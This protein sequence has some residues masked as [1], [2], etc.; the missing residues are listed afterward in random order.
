MQKGVG[1]ALEKVL[2][3]KDSMLDEKKEDETKLEFMNRNRRD[4]YQ[5]LCI[6]PCSPS[7]AISKETGLSIHAVNWHLRR[8]Y[9]RDYVH[10]EK[11]GKKTIFYPV[12]LIHQED[13]PIF[14]ILNIKRARDIFLAIVD[15]N[16]ISQKEICK[17]LGLKHQAVIW[18]ANK[19][20]KLGLITSL[21]DGKYRRYYPTELLNK[22]KDE[23]MKRI[24]IFKNQIINKL[25]NEM[26]TP[27]ILRS[28]DDKII[29]RIS[30]GRNRAV[31]TLCTDPFVTVL[32]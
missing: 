18:Y 10:K 22:K 14:E 8:L 28:T 30:R 32:S 12:N 1:K 29:I 11:R 16:G 3:T 13:I 24:R 17:N 27:S 7:S 2:T 20:K 9:D 23:N 15:K 5:F 26:L 19:L 4:I 21:E 6:H 31:L 25:Q